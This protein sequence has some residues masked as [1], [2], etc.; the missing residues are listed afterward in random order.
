MDSKGTF[1]PV[2]V[3]LAEKLGLPGESMSE[4]SLTEA[5]VFKL[6]GTRFDEERM[7]ATEASVVGHF[8]VRLLVAEAL[9]A[10]TD[11]GLLVRVETLVVLRP[12]APP[13]ERPGQASYNGI[14]ADDLRAVLNED[15]LVAG[16]GYSMDRGAAFSRTNHAL[17]CAECAHDPAHVQGFAVVFDE[18]VDDL[19]EDGF[20]AEIVSYV[21]LPDVEEC[22]SVSA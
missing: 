16:P 21:R 15:V 9:D 22:E 12:D 6:A 1:E 14:T 3:I 7:E 19:I 18:A 11:E 4:E 2:K 10:L 13:T 20:L 5:V 8:R 17:N